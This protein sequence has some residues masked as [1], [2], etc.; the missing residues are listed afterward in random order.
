MDSENDLTAGLQRG[1]YSFRNLH[2]A[3]AEETFA[4]LDL[5]LIAER[6]NAI[7]R[8]DPVINPVF[9]PMFALAKVM[10]Y[11]NFNTQCKCID[12]DSETEAE[13]IA[14]EIASAAMDSNVAYRKGIRYVERLETFQPL[15]MELKPTGIR[16]KGV[17]VITGGT[18]GL[19]LQVAHYLSVQNQVTLILINRSCFPDKKE[20]AAIAADPAN[21][22]SDKVKSLQQVEGRGSQVRCYQADVSCPEDMIS[23]LDEVRETYGSIHGVIHSA[24]IGTGAR[25]VSIQ[26]QEEEDFLRTLAPKVQGTWLLDRLTQQD[27]LDFMVLFTSPVTLIGGVGLSGYTCS[28]SFL[29]S[30][31]HYRNTGGK[32]TIAMS[33]APWEFTVQLMGERFNPQKQL[34]QVISSERVRE[35]FHDILNHDVQESIIGG[36]NYQGELLP[37]YKEFSFRLSDSIIERIKGGLEQASS[38]QRV[39][40]VRYKGEKVPP[41]GH[42]E[43]LGQIIG[44]VLGM[45]KL[46]LESNFFELGGDSII[47][48][49]V[50]VQINQVFQT[51]LKVTDLLRFPDLHAFTGFIAEQTMV[52][53]SSQNTARDIS[54]DI[55]LA[56]EQNYYPVTPIQRGIFIIEEL[57]NAGCSYNMT[58]VVRITGN[59]DLNRLEKAFGALIRRHEAL[60]TAFRIADGEVVQTVQSDVP[61]IVT[62]KQVETEEEIRHYLKAFIRPFHLLSAPLARLEVLAAGTEQFI[63][64]FDIHHIVSDAV[65]LS[66][67]TKELSSLY[68]GERLEPVRIHFKDYAYVRG[69]QCEHNEMAADLEYWDAKLNRPAISFE[70]QTDFPRGPIREFAGDTVTLDVSGDVNRGLFRLAHQSGGTLFMSLFAAFHILLMRV[71]G[72]EDVIVG[73]P[74]ALRDQPALEGLVGNL[75]NVVPVR[76]RPVPEDTF[77]GFFARFRSE[78]LQSFEHKELYYDEMVSLWNAPRHVSRNPIFDVVFAMQNIPIPQASFGRLQANPYRYENS[79]SKYDLTLNIQDYDGVLSC[80]MDYNT[81]L[82]QKETAEEL[83]RQ[84]TTILEAVAGNGD[85]QL[86]RINLDDPSKISRKVDLESVEF[87]W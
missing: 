9:A 71:S 72:Y 69:K 36:L 82:Y 70:L 64:C 14:N 38:Y 66:I 68:N 37:Y 5:Y 54:R 13:V 76:T 61:G 74:I 44:G 6:V 25:G 34:F 28:N 11:E 67:L 1:V 65:S 29:D 56:P 12:I 21:A 30:F 53:D 75:V 84:Y 16:P 23:V 81:K 47:A 79:N 22:L 4:D 20:W 62:V 39:V 86:A 52:E 31:V 42:S 49:K 7:H 2:L 55:L 18:G 43:S 8:S 63:L 27:K 33:W 73:T 57:G 58:N 10:K 59:F 78:V 35:A 80:N 41:H 26:E 51:A 19:G 17:Y 40:E 24:G 87:D 45:E 15:D 85:I 50:I 32:R 60:R 77:N 3:L 46:D 83:L 48:M